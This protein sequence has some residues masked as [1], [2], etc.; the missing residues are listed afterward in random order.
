MDAPKEDS[1]FREINVTPV[2]ARAFKKV[3]YHTQARK[4]IEN[5]LPAYRQGENCTD[6]FVTIQHND[7]VFL[8]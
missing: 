4:V 1:D 2:I 8:L 3:V 6:A 5:S 7:F